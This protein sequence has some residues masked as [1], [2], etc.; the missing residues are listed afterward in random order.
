MRRGEGPNVAKFPKTEKRPRNREVTKNPTPYHDP[1]PAMSGNAT[2]LKDKIH[3]AKER[4]YRSH[5]VSFTMLL[6]RANGLNNTL[7]FIMGE[8]LPL[9][10]LGLISQCLGIANFFIHEPRDVS[11]DVG[12]LIFVDLVSIEKRAKDSL[13]HPLYLSLGGV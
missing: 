3:N 10:P 6:L 12:V 7:D 11:I 2:I 1:M 4:L 13:D 8:L 9:V 5:T